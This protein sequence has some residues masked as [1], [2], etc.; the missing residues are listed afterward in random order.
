MLNTRLPAAHEVPPLDP[1]MDHAPSRA[2][3]RA[4]ALTCI[5]AL[6][7]VYGDIG[8]S[9]LYTVSEVFYGQ[10]A[11][12][13]TP[14]NALGATSLVLWVLTLSVSLKY[15]LLVLRA[16]NRGEGGVFALL[17][18][19]RETRATRLLAWLTP[20][21]ILAAGLLYG[22]GVITPAISVLSAVEGLRVATVALEPYVV[23][24]TVVLLVGLFAIQR[25]GTARV[26]RLFGP[27]MLVW[28]AVIGAL[29]VAQVVAHPAILAAANPYH[30]VHFLVG[31]GLRPM[32]AILGSVLLAVTGCEALFADMGHFGR[33]PIRLAWGG[34]VY[35]AL[36]LN[37]L[38]QGAFV[39][40][41]GTASHG[42]LFYALV[43]EWGLYPM[44]VLA[45]GATIVASQAL[46]SGAF[47]LTQQAISLGLFPRLR[48]VH[49]SD[50]QQGQIYVATI[51][52][53]LMVA[54]VLLVVTFRTSSNLAAAYG[55]AV[56]GVMLVTS[57]SMIAVATRVWSW[58]WWRAVPVFG[59]FACMEALFFASASLKILHG[60]WIPL[61]IGA[62]I[63]G[64]MSTWY[65][66]RTIVARQYS[67]MAPHCE[68]VARLVELK[69]N[70]V[71]AQIPRSVVVMSS[72]PITRMEDR[73]PPALHV[74]WVRLGA[75]PKHVVFLTVVNGNLP[76]QPRN[77]RSVYSTA[78]FLHD[79]TF[80]SVTSVQAF[81]GYMESPD[82]R[83]ALARAKV[84]AGIRVPGNPRRWLVLVGQENIIIAS[85]GWFSRLR[86]SA[87]RFLLHNSVPAHIYFGLSK[88]THVTSEVVHL[89]SVAGSAATDA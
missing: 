12:A 81:Y 86:L 64:V 68:T 46:I 82:V 26:G 51:N 76:V 52:W 58:P 75:L 2:R 39:H 4:L 74:F 40:G 63:Y 35:P 18:L 49:T 13:A 70:P 44:V 87:F 6:G 56:S 21:L 78:T 24:I 66:G 73:I 23:P 34:L 80:G 43:P 9:P 14:E 71:V 50:S 28:F 79:D 84:E 25:H 54:A 61:Q 37:Y 60:G 8:T 15:V 16:D 11:A 85:G 19:L 69:R 38:G 31:E 83:Q 57:L 48:I 72:R 67:A 47:S 22:E 41:G 45:T 10:G 1:A 77:G 55:F 5:T 17:A 3:G 27:L 42:H 30:A 33:R 65:W 7:V 20:A 53:L 29:G 59:G 89:P 32:M 36:V 62:V 88:D